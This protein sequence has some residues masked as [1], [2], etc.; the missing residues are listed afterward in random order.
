MI[1]MFNN[2]LIEVPVELCI[3]FEVISA[4]YLRQHKAEEGSDLGTLMTDANTVTAELVN[5]DYLRMN[6]MLY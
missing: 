2:I 4:C 3:N 5:A 6:A 1:E